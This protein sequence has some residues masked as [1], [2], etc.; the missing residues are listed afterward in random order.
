MKDEGWKIK[1]IEYIEWNLISAIIRSWKYLVIF[2]D[3]LLH[4][5]SIF[6]HV[7]TVR[8]DKIIIKIEIKITFKYRIERNPFYFILDNAILQYHQI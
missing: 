3:F 6:N 1:W 5:Y 8:Y 4:Y 2:E 7:H